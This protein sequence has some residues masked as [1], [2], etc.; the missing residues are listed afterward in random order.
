MGASFLMAKK[1]SPV[2]SQAC[3]IIREHWGDIHPHA[4]LICGSGWGEIID[5]LSPISSIA[6]EQIE[7]MGSTTVDG[8]QG[9]LWLAKPGG[10]DVLVFQ[11]RRHFYE[12]AGWN[13]VV[14]PSLLSHELG[15]RSLILTNASGGIRED[16][17]PGDFMVIEDHLN[18]MGDN[19]L[20][21]ALAHPKVPR[22]PDQSKVY[23]PAIQ[24]KLQ[25]SGEA[26][27]Q[28]LK[29]GVY[30]ALS[31]PAFETPAEIHAFEKLGADAV[32]MST[33][34]E[35]MMANALGLQIG[36]VS[37]ISNLAAGLSAKALS[38]E[39]VTRTAA[40]A[41]PNMTRLLDHFLPSLAE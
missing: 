9:K 31:G 27:G 28:K 34:P 14:F 16:L 4:C 1:T 22:F 6:Y 30:L 37:C 38:H 36:A 11:G 20:M 23:S 41:L 8:H 5:G 29:T 7:G 35:A 40:L 12:G 3:E 2:I 13:P 18:F 32:G 19:P 15:V 24:K 33:V 21:G 26:I 39:D 10:L 25:V 17:L